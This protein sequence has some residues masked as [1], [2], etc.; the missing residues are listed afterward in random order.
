M[1]RL[2]L[3][4][5]TLLFSLI[6]LSLLFWNCEKDSS[7][8]LIFDDNIVASKKYGGGDGTE[9]NPY[10]ISDARHL[11]KLVH[12]SKVNSKT[13]FKL[14]VDIQITASEWIP[15]KYGRNFNGF[16]HVI[17]GTLKSDKCPTFGFFEVLESGTTIS[18]LTIAA[19][20][21]NLYL[22][23]N[24]TNTGAIAGRTD[25]GVTIK[26]CNII[27]KV[28]S[29]NSDDTNTGG[30]VGI[31]NNSSY[32]YWGTLEISNC[33]VTGEVSTRSDSKKSWTGGI[34]GGG[35]ANISN[36]DVNSTIIGGK[37]ISGGIVGVFSSGYMHSCLNKGDVY[38]ESTDIGGLAGKNN[39]HIYSCCTNRG[40]VNGQPANENNQIGSGNAIEPCKD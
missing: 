26:N 34:L 21:E 14:T 24:N 16:G 37:S 32:S 27:G 5:F 4:V 17:S 25:A 30:I 8:K 31:A 9:N 13:C 35:D 36:C 18:N 20:V 3:L 10:I 11:K 40:N 29:I 6:C 15:I 7:S 28:V 39:G 23:Q 33:S 1:K 38:S 12:D 2:T 22:G 19:T